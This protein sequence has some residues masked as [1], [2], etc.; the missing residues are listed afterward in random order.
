VPRLFIAL[1]VPSNP[2][3]ERVLRQFHGLRGVSPV[4]GE[5]LHYTLRF[6]GD[7]S[8]ETKNLLLSILEKA[9]IDERPFPLHIQGTGAFPNA[10]RPRVVWA[11]CAKQDE[12]PM[13]ELARHVDDF[14][15]EIGLGERDKPFVPHLTLARIKNP[16]GRGLEA[17][18]AI[19][20]VER[21]THYATMTAKALHLVE[22]TLTPEGPR[23]EDLLE[24]PLQ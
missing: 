16:G 8:D 10:S 5:N 2:T 21:E 9:H 12:A 24:V 23:Y 4:R 20:H 15:K 3:F 1:R 6:L 19:L 17:A 11:G 18:K 13:L 7:V 14:T 22:S